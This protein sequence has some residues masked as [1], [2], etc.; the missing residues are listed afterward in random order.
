[1]K[2]ITFE[3]TYTSQSWAI[4]RENETDLLNETSENDFETTEDAPF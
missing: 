1:M 3:K 4:R 2:F